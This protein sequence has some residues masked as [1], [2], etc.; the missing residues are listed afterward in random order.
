MNGAIRN[1]DEQIGMRLA[2][3]RLSSQHSIEQLS[4][5][6]GVTPEQLLALESGA[7][8][9]DAA[10]LSRIAKLLDL[11]VRMFFDEYCN[12]QQESPIE[13]I[14][15]VQT[16]RLFADLVRAWREEADGLRAA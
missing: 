11:E 3:A 1:L 6:V 9:A 15:A 13:L 5:L 4:A 14:K 16:N 12:M 7:A 2:Q 10:F 8:R